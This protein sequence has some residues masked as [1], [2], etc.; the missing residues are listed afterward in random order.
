VFQAFVFGAIDSQNDELGLLEGTE[1][2]FRKAS[3]PLLVEF[4]KNC[5]PFGMKNFVFTDFQIEME[6]RLGGN[7]LDFAN[8]PLGFRFE[9]N[10][11]EIFL[12]T[13]RWCLW[14][15]DF[16]EELKFLLIAVVDQARDLNA[17]RNRPAG[18]TNFKSRR[19][20]PFDNRWSA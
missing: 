10:F 14:R 8:E 16:K 7:T 15:G 2:P 4:L 11:F 3:W 13:D 1:F 12:L 19:E 17:F 9:R 20:R 5:A 18:R 6:G